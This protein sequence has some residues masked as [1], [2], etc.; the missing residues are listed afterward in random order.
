[1]WRP[2]EVVAV[3]R[4][5]GELWD[6][7]PGLTGMRGPLLALTRGVQS[8]LAAFAATET[9]DEWCVPPGIALETLERAEYFASFPQWLTAISHLSGDEDVLERVATAASPAAAARQAMAPASAALSPAVCYHTYAGLEGSSIESPRIMTAE[10]TCWRH[11]G[12]R[13]LTLERGWAF[14][15]REIVCVGTAAHC[16]EFRQRGMARAIDLAGS[17]GLPVDTVEA[18]DPFFAPTARG[19]AVLQRVKSLKHELTVRFPDGRP[20]AIASFNNHE[21]FFGQAFDIALC[22]GSPASSACVAFGVERWALAVLVV[23]GPLAG[24]WPPTLFTEVDRL[25][26]EHQC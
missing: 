18:G 5:R 7:A 23:H 16:E 1:M 24:G 10:G 26:P 22:D 15:M 21:R 6:A 9:D 25:I 8:T 19:R 13:L 12:H 14:R 3:L 4:A 17:L 20:L 11:E 2:E